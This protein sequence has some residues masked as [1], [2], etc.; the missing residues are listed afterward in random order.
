MTTARRSLDE[1]VCADVTD[2]VDLDA[3]EPR[4]GQ[5]QRST[6]Q[7]L[8][9]M[10][11]EALV[12]GSVTGHTWQLACD[13]GP[14]LDATDVAPN[15][16]AVLGTGMVSSF[17]EGIQTLATRR[18]LELR[19]LTL[20]LDNRYTSNGSALQG[21]M[22]GSALPPELEVVVDSPAD[23]AELTA[24]AEDAVERSPVTGLLAESRPSRFNLVHNGRPVAPDRVAALDRLPADD[25]AAVFDRLPL[26]PRGDGP[27]LVRHTN[28]LTEEWAGDDEGY[29]GLDFS[30]MRDEHDRTLHLRFTSTARPEGGKHVVHD[31][32]SPRGSVFEFVSDEPAGHGGDGLAPDAMTYVA[33]GIGFCFMTQLGR[34]AS[35]VGEELEAFRIVQDTHVSG[36]EDTWTDG[37]GAAA[38]VETDLFVETDADDD[39][40]RDLLDM[41]EQTCYAHAACRQADLVPDVT[42]T[43]A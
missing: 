18:D 10:Q 43:R 14:W 12:T 22:T 21:T 25:P 4:L 3:P 6:Y 19:E 2:A 42:V 29:T 15:P 5:A 11:K 24:L 7:A 20:V 9:Y 27:P 38:P 32:Y 1:P 34:Y 37:P 28:E 41:A 30:T 8:E 23:R 26:E 17:H 36:G 31:M 16:L 13:E 35:L 40:A 33:A 39:F